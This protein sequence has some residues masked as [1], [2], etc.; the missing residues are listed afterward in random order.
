MREIEL[1]I[2]ILVISV[3]MISFVCASGFSPSS[4]I[5][6]L[7]KGQEECKK[8][9]IIS[10]S[11]KITIEDKWA[12]NK[13]V[14]WKV[15]LFETS[16]SELGLSL[17]YPSSLSLDQR[18]AEI[19]LSGSKEGEY[20]GV[21]LLKEGQVGNSIIQMGV[22]VKATISGQNTG[23]SQEITT[24][25]DSGVGVQ[26]NDEET[27]ETTIPQD[28]TEET[29]QTANE[30]QQ[31]TTNLGI[32]GAAIGTENGIWNG[33]TIGVIIGAVL[34]VLVVAILGYIK[35]RGRLKS[36]GYI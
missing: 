15:S 30:E 34:V 4:L 32:T 9:S 7:N 26:D 22:W 10:N 2:S 18:Q 12:E 21:I 27:A 23:S 25:Q 35:R 17:T 1:T 31:Q 11:D 13:D 5:F 36:E 20:H 8:I 19:C 14:E 3:I 28:V 24:A 33:K 6:N 29:E 16:A